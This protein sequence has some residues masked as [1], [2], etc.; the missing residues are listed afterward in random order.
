MLAKRLGC[1]RLL[2]LVCVTGWLEEA[3]VLN[4]GTR[5]KGS[6]SEET[7]TG[8]YPYIGRTAFPVLV[9]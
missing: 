6:P 1:G 5:F 2:L 9:A 3:F 4:C 8:R 7:R